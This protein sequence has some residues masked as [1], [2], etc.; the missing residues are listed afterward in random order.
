MSQVQIGESVQ[1]NTGIF[2]FKS[3]GKI[4]GSAGDLKDLI[5]EM[6][7]LEYEDPAA[8]RYHLVEGHIVQWLR[9]V[10]EEELAEKLDGVSNISLAERLVQEQLE[11]SNNLSRM[12]RGRMH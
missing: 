5:K 11:R 1:S 10:K 12:R 3:Y 8:L 6:R 7:R 2:Y 9:S 4:I